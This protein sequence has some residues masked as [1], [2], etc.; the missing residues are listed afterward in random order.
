MERIV[1]YDAITFLEASFH[2]KLELPEVR[3][4]TSLFTIINSRPGSVSDRLWI[5]KKYLLSNKVRG[6]RYKKNNER[7][8]FLEQEGR[9]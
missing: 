9:K 5:L 8:I 2:W 6:P 1:N 7:K 3:I 4:L